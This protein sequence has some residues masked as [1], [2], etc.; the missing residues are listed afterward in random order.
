MVPAG[1]AEYVVIE[2]SVEHY[3]CGEAVG[4]IREAHRILAPGGSLVVT[5][6]NMRALAQAW[7]RG[8]LTTQVWMT[9]CYG[10]FMGHEADRHRWGFDPQTLVTFLDAAAKWSKVQ[11]YNWEPM[12]GVTPARDFWILGARCVK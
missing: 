11:M 1:D 2:Q 10:A 12:L 8:D 3:G 6:P 7:L 5:V 9:S 4:L